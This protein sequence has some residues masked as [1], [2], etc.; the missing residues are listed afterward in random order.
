MSATLELTRRLIALPSITPEDAGCQALL[1]ATL[2]ELGFR[3][4]TL[5]FGEVTNLWAVWGERGPLFVFAG[6]TDVVPPG[7]TADWRSDP[8]EP[9]ERDGYLFGRG[10]ADMKG[11]LAAMLTATSAFLG[12]H[13]PHARIG[14]LITS[15]EEGSAVDGTRRV[16]AELQRRGEQIDYCLVGEPSSSQAVGDTI[17]IGRRGSLSGR[18]RVKGIQG[19]VAYPHLAD[20]P[21]H[22]ALPALAALST[23]VWDNG[24]AAFPATSF[25]ISNINA[26]TGANNVIPETLTLDFNLRYSTELDAETIKS[27]VV[28]ILKN[29]ALDYTIDWHLSGEPFLTEDGTLIKAVEHAIA[30][31]T[32]SAPERSTAGGTSD[33]RFIAPTGAEVVEL[34]P[35]NA[36]IH[37]ID[38]C[39][40][41][42]DLER[43]AEIYQRLLEQVLLQRL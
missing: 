8:F 41:I 18:M 11:S 25:Q 32:G 5:Q 10:A 9:C 19:H 3:V 1:G 31:V 21:I 28:A 13:Q 14:F 42:A 16:M 7:N 17:K 2:S 22:K 40:R 20:N 23:E 26:G 15:D 12:S 33:G 29:F 6:H 24:N 4:E 38:E 39:V 43:L 35:C 30:A 37:K 34:G 36:T 27:R